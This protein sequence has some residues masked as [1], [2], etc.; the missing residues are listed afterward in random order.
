[1][2]ISR[3]NAKYIDFSDNTYSLVPSCITS[4]PPVTLVESIRRYGILHPPV[5]KEKSTSTFTIVSGRKRLLA[6]I[7]TTAATSFDCHKLTEKTAEID[8]LA[9]CLEDARLSRPLTPVERAIFYKKALAQIDEKELASRFLPMLGF[10]RSVYHIQKDLK[11]LDLEEPLLVALHE[12]LLDD[13][14]AFEL[15]KLSF[16]DRLSLFEVINTLHLSVGNQ[17][18]LVICCRELAARQNTS[19][20]SLL[21]NQAV[22]EIINH[23]EANTPQKA[24]NLMQWLVTER[25]PRLMQAEKEFQRFV[26]ELALPEEA[27]LEHSPYFEKDELVF[28]LSCADRESFLAVWE[29]IRGILPTS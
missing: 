24:T 9:L 26:T 27:R 15:A 3:I 2:H 12:G 10:S 13:K 22:D 7:E 5:V 28:T 17:K 4:T 21:R 1:M 8:I 16:S 11:V 25:F 19:I 6:A 20:S 29:K 23:E 18:K 14:V